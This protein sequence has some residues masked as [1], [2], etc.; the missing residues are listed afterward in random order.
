M[1]RGWGGY[2]ITNVPSFSVRR[3]KSI[4]H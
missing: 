4:Y 3:N 2:P 1:W